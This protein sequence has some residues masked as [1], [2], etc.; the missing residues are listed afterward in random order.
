MP[1][2]IRLFRT[3]SVIRRLQPWI[4]VLLLGVWACSLATALPGYADARAV[5]S[6]VDDPAGSA[7]P[8][9]QELCGEEEQEALMESRAVW[10]WNADTSR[11]IAGADAAL[12]N[13]PLADPPLIP[14]EW[15]QT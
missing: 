12:R 2:P 8:A 7:D 15:A 9:A 1:H 13:R 11:R 4:A 3:R 6:A 14:P 10:L 5:V